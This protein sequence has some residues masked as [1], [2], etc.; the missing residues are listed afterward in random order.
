M[1]TKSTTTAKSISSIHPIPS[2]FVGRIKSFLIEQKY[3]GYVAAILL[4]LEVVINVLVVLK[5]PYTEIDWSTYMQQI[6]LYDNG[7]RDYTKLEGSTGPVVYPAGFIYVFALLRSVTSNGTDIRRAQWIFAALCVAFT[8]VVF[9][10]Y[11]RTRSV[12]GYVLLFLILSKRIHS[13]F[14]LRLF[15]DCISMFLFYVALYL[16][17]RHRW[18]IGC[19]FFSLAVGIK[20]NLLLFA[21][22]LLLLLLQTYGV[23]KTVP[24]LAICAIVQVL[25]GVPFL[26]RNPVGY[27]ARAFEF[28][29]QFMYKWTVNWRFVPVDV[30]LSKPWA[31]ALLACHLFVLSLFVWKWCRAQGGLLNSIRLSS[32]SSQPKRYLSPDYIVTLMF[33]ANIVGMTFS[34]SLHYQFY[35][36]YFHSLAFLLWHCPMLPVPLRI[37]ILGAIEYCWNVYPSTDFS[38]I[39]LFICNVLIV[40]SIMLAP[41]PPMLINPAINQQAKDN[42]KKQ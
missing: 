8:A 14:G 2:D 3:V 11:K 10:I 25:L 31:I 18:S 5:V 13:I 26:M 1:K 27:V 7:E 34:R 23:A 9:A 19:V 33:T 41:T 39:L 24:R 6:E 20:M 30:F 38:S 29:R 4:L 36:W 42:K 22:A 37:T 40:A 17:T 21:P 12:P 32:P 35:L 15:N 28:S 16:F